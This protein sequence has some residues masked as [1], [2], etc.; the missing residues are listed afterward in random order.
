MQRGQDDLKRGFVGIFRVRINRDAAAII[1]D[2][3]AVADTQ[4]DLNPV[5][6]TRN[7]FIHRVVEHFRGEMVQRAFVNPANIHSGT[8][9]NRLQPLQHL[10]GR[11]G[12]IIGSSSGRSTASEK[13]VIHV[14]RIGGGESWAQA[15]CVGNLWNG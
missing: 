15:G 3:Q 12:I 7:R 4:I 8:A 14:K 10:N 6:M 13:I 11:G 5:G 2:R 9:A 1:A